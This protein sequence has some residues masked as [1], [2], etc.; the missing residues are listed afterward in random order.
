MR[1]EKVHQ[2]DA[3][4]VRLWHYADVLNTLTNVRYRG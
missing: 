4:R 2:R 1:R 3:I